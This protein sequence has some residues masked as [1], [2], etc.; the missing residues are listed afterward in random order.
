MSESTNTSPID[1]LEQK[2]QEKRSLYNQ[3]LAADKEFEEVK[4]L[5][6]EIREIEKTLEQSQSSSNTG[7]FNSHS[8]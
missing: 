8:S 5:F 4:T 6:V 3:M 2:L 7:A 1:L